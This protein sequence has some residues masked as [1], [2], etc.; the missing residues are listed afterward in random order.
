MIQRL[1]RELAQGF[2]AAAEADD[3]LPI[4]SER[5]RVKYWLPERIDAGEWLCL[6]G[7]NERDDTRGDSVL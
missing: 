5:D 4:G 2:V 3:W 7:L 6:I 1:S